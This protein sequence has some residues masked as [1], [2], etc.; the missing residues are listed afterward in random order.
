M[1]LRI[2]VNV[3]NVGHEEDYHKEDDG[4]AEEG[5]D[6]GDHDDEHEYIGERIDEPFD[7]DDHLFEGS[8]RTLYDEPHDR[9][10]EFSPED[11]R[12]VTVFVVD[13]GCQDS[14]NQQ[15][16]HHVKSTDPIEAKPDDRIGAENDNKGDRSFIVGVVIVLIDISPFIGVQ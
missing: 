3:H 16:L 7:D 8:L 12:K 13:S 10:D 5:S 14:R 9:K 15:F 1:G 4:C 2:E 11:N 6:S